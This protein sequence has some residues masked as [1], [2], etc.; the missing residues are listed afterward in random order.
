MTTESCTEQKLRHAF[1]R[2]ITELAERFADDFAM[3]KLEMVQEFQGACLIIEQELITSAM[4][5]LQDKY[6]VDLAAHQEANTHPDDVPPTLMWYDG[7]ANPR[8]PSCGGHLDRLGYFAHQGGW[9]VLGFQRRQWLYKQCGNCHLD[10]NLSHLG[11]PTNRGDPQTEDV[12][13]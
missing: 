6:S 7:V 13:Q 5:R 11:V 3:F 1:R 12:T 9:L 8:C 4:L 10:W 2:G